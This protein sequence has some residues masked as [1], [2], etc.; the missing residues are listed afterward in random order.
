MSADIYIIRSHEKL[1]LHLGRPIGR[2]HS[3]KNSSF[4]CLKK[5]SVLRG[6]MAGF[7]RDGALQRDEADKPK[8]S[9]N[10]ESKEAEVESEDL[11]DQY[12]SFAL[13]LSGP[14]S[15]FLQLLEYASRL[16]R[17]RLIYKRKSLGR[18]KISTED[19]GAKTE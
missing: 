1:S 6:E 5:L 16:P 17:S 10:M 3:P 14:F 13:V 2:R 4:L 7:F 15:D 8:R 11:M 19:Q 12:I 18:L 9:D